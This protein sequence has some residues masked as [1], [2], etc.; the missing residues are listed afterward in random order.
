MTSQKNVCAGGELH[1]HTHTHT[2]KK[3]VLDKLL[4]IFRKEKQLVC[5]T[6]TLTRVSEFTPLVTKAEWS[7]KRIL[8]LKHLASTELV[9]HLKCLNGDKK[10]QSSADIHDN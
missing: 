6:Y 1:L 10:F 8:L 9:V 7:V 4:L 2:H 5:V 3:K